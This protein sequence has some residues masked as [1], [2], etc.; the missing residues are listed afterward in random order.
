MEPRR[1]GAN[2]LKFAGRLVLGLFLIVLSS[3]STKTFYDFF[4]ALSVFDVNI[5]QFFYGVLAYLFF[6]LFIFKP[7]YL[8]IFGHEITHA[9]AG[10]LC[11]ARITEFKVSK[12]GG[13]VRLTKSNL[14]IDLAPYFIPVYTLFLFLA[15]WLVKHFFDSGSEYH[16]IY[17]FGTGFSIAFHIIMTRDVLRIKQPDLK[18]FGAIFSL[19]LIYAFNLFIVALII[20]IIIDKS[21]VSAYLY[22]L[23]ADMRV[24]AS[25]VFRQLFL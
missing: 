20:C 9:L 17:I 10:V 2:V 16:R 8:Y 12:G 19:L 1:L 7:D 14:F 5:F 15:Y 13:H 23:C 18:K 11:G 25:G 24:I 22:P 21:I 3:A 6:H 4:T